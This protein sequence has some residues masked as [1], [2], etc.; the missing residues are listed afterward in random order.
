MESKFAEYIGSRIGK[1]E[2]LSISSYRAHNKTY[3][4]CKC[5]C[6]SVRRVSA[7][8]LVRGVVKGCQNC[9]NRDSTNINWSGYQGIYG[10]YLGELR[11]SCKRRKG[12]KAEINVNSEYL[13]DLFSQQKGI[14]AL[15]GLE[16]TLAKDS[17][18]YKQSTA[19]PDRIDSTKGYVEGNLQWVHKDINRMKTDFSQQKF[20]EL[21]QS[22]HSYQEERKR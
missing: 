14:C 5:E 10:K 22:V 1:L 17:Y 7:S 8:K 2:V 3:F 12:E 21:C 6:G 18:S 11:S 15:S 4:E 13:W 19:S 16:I 20:I 9:K